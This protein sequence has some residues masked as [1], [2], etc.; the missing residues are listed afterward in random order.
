MEVL[1]S[2]AFR[3]SAYRGKVVFVNLFA[4]WCGPCNEEKPVVVAFARGTP[5]TPR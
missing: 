5:T 1:D 4:T 2:P 3:L